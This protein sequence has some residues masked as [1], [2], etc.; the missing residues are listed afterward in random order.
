MGEG[1]EGGGPGGEGDRTS[2]GVLGCTA[3]LGSCNLGQSD[4]WSVSFHGPLGTKLN[5]VV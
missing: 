2:H 5:S 4:L 3:T 1:R